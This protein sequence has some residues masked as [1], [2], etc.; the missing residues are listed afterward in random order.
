[1]GGCFLCEPFQKVDYEGLVPIAPLSC[2]VNRVFQTILTVEPVYRETPEGQ[3]IPWILT[4][5]HKTRLMTP[6]IVA[7]IVNLGGAYWQR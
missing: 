4:L 6:E 1:V 2:T 5:N 7:V 3:P